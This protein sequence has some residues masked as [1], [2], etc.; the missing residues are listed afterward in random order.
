MAATPSEVLELNRVSVDNTAN[1]KTLAQLGLVLNPHA[2]SVSLMNMGADNIY[3]AKADVATK[4]YILIAYSG[5]ILH[6]A[7]SSVRL[8]FFY[9]PVAATDMNVQQEAL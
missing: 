3:I 2:N 8:L 5:V 6:V 4:G 1:G 9:T 7:V